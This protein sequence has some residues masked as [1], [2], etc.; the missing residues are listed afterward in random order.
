MKRLIKASEYYEVCS[1]CGFEKEERVMEDSE[2]GRI[3][4]QCALDIHPTPCQE[5]GTDVPKCELYQTYD[6]QGI[7][8]RRVCEKCNRKIDARGYDGQ[9]YDERDENL[10]YDY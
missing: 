8:F 4:W 3:C 2:Q 6:C 5:C 7:P 9:Y 10:D 1:I